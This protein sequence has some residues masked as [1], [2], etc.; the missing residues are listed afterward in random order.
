MTNCFTVEPLNELQ[1]L[2]FE[3]IGQM[4][5]I[6]QLR[7]LNFHINLTAIESL[8][9]ELN[10]ELELI[11]EHCK[12]DE[13]HKSEIE[14]LSKVLLIKKSELKDILYGVIPLK[15]VTER[16][17]RKRDFLGFL[18]A[19]D[20]RKIEMDLETLRDTANR[21]IDSHHELKKGVYDIVST[22]VNGTNEEL[23]KRNAISDAR[24]K[25]DEIEKKI[26]SI[27][28]ILLRE[29]LSGDI[30]SYMEFQVSLES[31][32]KTLSHDEE[33][34]YQKLIEYYY[35]L[36]LTHTVDGNI[37]KLEMH[38]PIVEKYPREL[39]KIIEIPARYKDK[40]IMTD[41]EW[42][43]MAINSNDTM[44][45]MSLDSCYK[46][47][48]RNT[49][50]YCEAQSPI[51]DSHNDC[52][53]NSFRKRKIDVTLC[54][55][56]SAQFSKL[57]FIRLND[58][59]YFYYTPTNETLN[60][61]CRTK[62]DKV[63]L[64]EHTT[65]IIEIESECSAISSKYRLIKTGRYQEVPYV[66]QNILSIYFDIAEVKENIEK[67]QSPILNNIFYVENSKLIKDMAAVFTD[68]PKIERLNFKA[69]FS[70]TEILLYLAM[71]G[72]VLF[73]VHLLYRACFW[74]RG[75]GAEKK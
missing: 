14:K 62:T 20:G 56:L 44:M 32:N 47:S 5:L 10:I 69:S 73:I 17:R 15:R 43:F 30:I 59:Q 68:V 22:L 29:R 23:A 24:V 67:T 58:G 6:T 71:I 18:D 46:A 13:K 66:K 74:C 63:D 11:K 51:I 65:G 41:V 33:L 34:P 57:T 72:L 70:N 42:K 40:L 55:T 9:D 4:K 27:I 35:N 38:V 3:E 75:C 50:Y 12:T 49:T 36:K 60:I 8:I 7:T 52:V 25:V 16:R 54:K 37:L 64:F 48:A 31:I 61:T 28:T 19:S 26:N 45:L 1:G 2:R 21:L 39:H 53:T